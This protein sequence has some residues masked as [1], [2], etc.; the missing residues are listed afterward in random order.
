MLPPVDDAVL[1]NNPDFASLYAKLTT[2]VLNPDGSSK[3]LPTAKEEGLITEALNEY[4]LKAAKQHLIV[5]ALR[6]ADPQALAAKQAP[7]PPSLSRRAGPPTRQPPPP[8]QAPATSPAVDLP[9]ALLDLLRLIPPLLEASADDIPA[10]EAA[11]LLSH[12]PLSDFPSHLG[13]L[14]TL[15]ST[16]LHRAAVQLARAA[17]PS[18]GSSYVHRSVPTLPAHASAL[19]ASAAARR[20]DLSR[21]RLAAATQLVS[22]LREQADVLAQLLRALEAKHGAVARSLELRATESALT[23]QRQQAEAD[24]ALWQAR[25]HIYTPEAVRALANYTS[26]LRDAKGRLA[27]AVNALQAE[28]GVYGVGAADGGNNK[29]QVLRDLARVYR[30]MDRQVGEVQEDLKRLGRA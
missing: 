29:E 28:L 15:V 9:P 13:S 18:N 6:N 23:A 16:T 8:Q 4:R 25:R 3:S 5:D 2:S 22:L 20:A 17:N 1:Q 24:A 11:V 27:E 10:E 7:P 30:D 26:H 21:A 12:P 19:A 14:A